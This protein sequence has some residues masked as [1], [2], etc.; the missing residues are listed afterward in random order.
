MDGV[1]SRHHALSVRAAYVVVVGMQ[2]R[3]ADEGYK[4]KKRNSSGRSLLALTV[5]EVRRLM[6]AVGAAGEQ[7]AFLLGWSR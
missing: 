6:Q 3:Q 5:P 4:V 7:Q 2:A 1:A